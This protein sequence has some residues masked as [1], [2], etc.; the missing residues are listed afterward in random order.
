MLENSIVSVARAIRRKEPGSLIEVTDIFFWIRKILVWNWVRER[1]GIL[2]PNLD[3]ARCN[4]TNSEDIVMTRSAR[5]SKYRI[6][7]VVGLG[8]FALATQ[9][10]ATYAGVRFQEVD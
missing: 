9:R 1:G 2:K 5:A 10:N 3:S 7:I 4:L 8:Q 6:R